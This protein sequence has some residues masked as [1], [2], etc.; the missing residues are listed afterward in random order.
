[1]L[2]AMRRIGDDPL[3]FLAEQWRT[4][5]D[6][7]QFPIP[8][9]P[10][11]MVSHPDDVRMVL[12]GRSRDV[13]KNTIQYRALSRVTGQGLLTSDNPVWREHRRILQPAFHPDTLPGVAA[14]T[15]RAASGLVDP[16]AR[17]WRRRGRGHRRRGDDPGPRSRRRLPVRPRARPGRRPPGRRHPDGP[18]RG[19]LDGQHAAAGTGWIPTPGNRRMARSLSELDAAVEAILAQRAAQGPSEPPDMLDLLQASSL[20]RAAVRDEIVTFLVAGHE[21]VASALTWALVL[22]GTHPDIADRVAQEADEVLGDPGPMDHRLIDM[23]GACPA[24]GRA[25]GGRRGDAPEP[26]RLADHPQHDRGHGARRLARPGRIPG[27]P[28]PV[29]RAP[30]PRGVG[31]P[32]GLPPGSLP[33]RQPRSPARHSAPRTSPSVPAPGCASAGTSPTPR[34]SCRWP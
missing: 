27:D 25:G 10:T 15:A 19:R 18:G 3:A 8:S 7:V 6:V 2:R 14:H 16:P 28:Q 23:A 24:P 21:T 33:R 20:D 30:P 34:R 22:L 31:R 17:A 9:P 5:G 26:A 4:H 32:R 13:T 12:V 1:M 29:D 11:Y